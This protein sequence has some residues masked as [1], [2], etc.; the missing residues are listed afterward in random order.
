MTPLKSVGHASPRVDAIKRVSGAATYTGDVQLPAMLFA[1]VLRSPHP[2]ARIKSIDVSKAQALAGVKAILTHE[3]CSVVW[4]SGD[5]KNKRYLFNNPVR[6]AGDAVAAVAV[7]GRIPGRCPRR[8]AVGRVG[9]DRDVDER[10]RPS[11]R[12]RRAAA[13]ARPPNRVRPAASERP[14]T[15]RDTFSRRRRALR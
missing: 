8:H 13:S 9:G 6:F 11:V 14:W 7:R 10:G 1:R 4:S 2:H 12:P 15:R 3:N 5:T